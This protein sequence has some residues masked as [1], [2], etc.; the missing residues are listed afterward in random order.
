MTEDE[1]R[2]REDQME[3]GFVLPPPAP[4]PLH[5]WGIRHIRFWWNVFQVERHASA[6]ASVGIGIGGPNIWDRWVLY[7]IY[8]GWC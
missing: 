2:W 6:W 7:A 1:K 3:H 5:V 4:W 8:R